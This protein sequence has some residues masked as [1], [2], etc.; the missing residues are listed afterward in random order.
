MDRGL[1][2]AQDLRSFIEGPTSAHRF[3]VE[4][5]PRTTAE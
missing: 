5:Q 2:L 3:I 4:E 1:D